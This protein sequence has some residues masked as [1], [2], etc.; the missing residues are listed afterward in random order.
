MS[1]AMEVYK[2]MRAL[3]TARGQLASHGIYNSLRNVEDV[4]TFMQHHVF[5][6]WDFMSLLKALQRTLTS[7]D[8]PWLPVGTPRTRRLIN[9]IVLEEESDE[10]DGKVTSHF[11]LYREAM[12]AAGADTGA[13]DAFVSAVRDGEPV[14]S[15]LELAGAPIGA[16]AFVIRTFDVIANGQAHAIAAVFT[17]GRE[18]PIPRMFSTLADRIMRTQPKELVIFK[19]YLDRH[20]ALDEDHHAPMAVEMLVELCGNDPDK[21]RDAGRAA[22]GALSA[23]LGLWS[24]IESEISLVRAGVQIRPAA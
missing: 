19:T 3:E 10:S 14:P 24:A 2:L 1:A 11:E 6:V 20:I 21:W 16:R 4:R 9:E 23:R 18:E 15:A 5:A 17:F 7:V 22:L 13:I 8:V 12:Q